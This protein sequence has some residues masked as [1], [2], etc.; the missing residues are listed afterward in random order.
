MFDLDGFDASRLA[1]DP[2]GVWLDLAA[3]ERDRGD[4]SILVLRLERLLETG[5][6][7]QEGAPGLH[8]DGRG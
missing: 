2:R 1:A 4:R 3:I 8:L 7:F 6:L 5:E